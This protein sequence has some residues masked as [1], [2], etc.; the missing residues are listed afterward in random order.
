MKLTI[1][2]TTKNCE[3]VACPTIYTNEAGNFIIQ[4]FKMDSDQKTNMNI[5]IP[6]G[7]ELIEVPK[8]F[9]EAFRIV[10]SY[11]KFSEVQRQELKSISS[12]DSIMNIKNS[13]RIPDN[14]I[15]CPPPENHSLRGCQR[16]M[17][18]TTRER[19]R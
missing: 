7:E 14:S 17:L 4:G 1:I 11:G 10:D 16:H 9:L 2:H 13:P 12:M 6:E 3:D 8:E 19:R 15:G 18:Q 5:K